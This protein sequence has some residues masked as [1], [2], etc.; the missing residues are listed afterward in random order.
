MST[1]RNSNASSWADASFEIVL[2][3]SLARRE[4]DSGDAR[5]TLN[6]TLSDTAGQKQT[7]SVARAVTADPIHVEVI[8]EAGTLVAGVA[9][10]I[11]LFAS[12]PDGR[13][14]Q[15]RLAISDLQNVSEFS[16]LAFNFSRTC[17][18]FPV[19]PR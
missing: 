8:P 7:K 11:Y 9:N 17:M 2:P 15:V 12:Y 14:A 16:P 18:E 5:F 13:P 4:Q 1:R 6:V 19:T 10:R 3:E